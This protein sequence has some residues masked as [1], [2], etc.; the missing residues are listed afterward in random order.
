MASSRYR[1]SGRVK[2]VLP[3]WFAKEQAH[4]CRDELLVRPLSPKRG[5]S[6]GD[7]SVH[8]VR[9]AATIKK[10][11]ISTLHHNRDRGSEEWRRERV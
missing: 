10:E 4:S 9:D 3:L 7:D 6:A 1:E 11:R 5:R 2:R 8:S